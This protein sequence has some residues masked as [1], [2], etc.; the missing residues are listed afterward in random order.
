MITPEY[1]LVPTQAVSAQGENY[2]AATESLSEKKLQHDQRR[3]DNKSKLTPSDGTDSQPRQTTEN[4]YSAQV[5]TSIAEQGVYMQA[6]GLAGHLT[7]SGFDS[8][9][10]YLSEAYMN[11]NSNH[12]H[13]TLSIFNLSC[14]IAQFKRNCY[15]I[16]PV[17]VIFAN[18]V[19]TEKNRLCWNSDRSRQKAS[20][21]QRHFCL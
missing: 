17:E 12:I 2:L 6:E 13:D 4:E 7:D 20:K 5:R 19:R 11:P 16:T 9:W 10:L 15:L 8:P 18:S 1:R 21:A 14:P 3:I